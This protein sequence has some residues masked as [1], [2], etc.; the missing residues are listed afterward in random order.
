MVDIPG[1]VFTLL[2]ECL[3]NSWLPQTWRCTTASCAVH[4]R[5]ARPKGPNVIGRTAMP[6]ETYA[7]TVSATQEQ[8]EDLGDFRQRIYASRLSVCPAAALSPQ[9]HSVAMRLRL[10][11]AAAQ[12][13]GARRKIILGKRLSRLAHC[14][15]A[16]LPNNGRVARS[17]A[18]NNLSRTYETDC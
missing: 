3:A 14:I 5:H 12:T 16:S 17:E 6:P 13:S 11:L 10:C 8:V 2:P 15:A 18:K 1:I 7:S 4:C 9:L